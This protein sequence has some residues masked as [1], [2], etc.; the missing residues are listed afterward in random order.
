MAPERAT[1]RLKLTVVIGRESGYFEESNLA[2]LATFKS[3]G[4]EGMLRTVERVCVTRKEE[5]VDED[6]LWWDLA[7]GLAGGLTARVGVGASELV[8]GRPSTGEA[9]YVVGSDTVC[10]STS[11]LSSSS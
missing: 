2:S 3:G 9:G 7:E 8:G 10:S 6:L 4:S 1:K 5:V 11:P